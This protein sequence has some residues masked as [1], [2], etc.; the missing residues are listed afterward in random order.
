MEAAAGW[1]KRGKKDWEGEGEDILVKP[2]MLVIL[3]HM[4][5][6]PGARDCAAYSA[7]DC[8]LKPAHSLVKPCNQSIRRWRKLRLRNI[9]PPNPLVAELGGP[10]HRYGA[11]GCA[12]CCLMDWM[13]F[14]NYTGLPFL[15]SPGSLAMGKVWDHILV[16]FWVCP[17]STFELLF[18]RKKHTYFAVSWA[19]SLG[20]SLEWEVAT[21]LFNSGDN[22]IA[23]GLGISLASFTEVK[24]S[25][26]GVGWRGEWDHKEDCCVPSLS[27]QH[28][29]EGHSGTF[30]KLP[31]SLLNSFYFQEFVIHVYPEF[32]TM[33][34]YISHIGCLYPAFLEGAC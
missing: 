25:S 23:P 10:P 6:L 19:S 17:K 29:R 27:L 12:G 28:P 33:S 4:R 8:L 5:F 21:R 18:K 14:G 9:K 1:W 2:V 31:C 30:L 16:C 3:V 13:R 7:S 24:S 22:L 26:V 20:T 15:M 11:G 34:E 32:L